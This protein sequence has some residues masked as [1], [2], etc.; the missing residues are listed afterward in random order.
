MLQRVVT[1]QQLDV[2]R[3]AVELLVDARLRGHG[4]GA[5][6]FERPSE[7]PR[8]AQRSAPDHDAP[9]AAGAH[10][11]GHVL[12]FGDIAVADD[13]NGTHRVHHLADPFPVGGT[14]EELDRPAAMDRDGGDAGRFQV[15]RQLRRHEMLRIP[16]QAHLG[17]DRY[18]P[19]GMPAHGFHDALGQLHRAAGVAQEE[20]AA[21]LLGHLVHRASHVDVDELR[22]VVDG[23]ARRL[24]QR[25]VPVAVEL[26]A[27][28][29]VEPV[30]GRQ[31]HALGR[32]AQD[33]GAVQEVG[34]GKPHAA[35]LTAEDAEGQVAVAGDGR[36]KQ[37]RFQPQRADVEALAAQP[38]VRFGGRRAHDEDSITASSSR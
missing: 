37:R 22:A 26:H 36:K 11:G 15:A 27:A 20:R 30:G 5:Q 18:A 24:R 9:A 25:V 28:G 14:A 34:A 23:P 29:L 31:L 13:G 12:R 7:E 6:E 1:L 2:P 4:A 8:R 3:D 33:G 16:A 17:G 21:V 32:A 38:G 10:E 35:L 19:V